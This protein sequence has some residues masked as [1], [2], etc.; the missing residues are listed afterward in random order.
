MN[1][2]FNSNKS[3]GGTQPGS[4]ATSTVEPDQPLSAAQIDQAVLEADE[5]WRQTGK[6][7]RYSQHL[8]KAL[9]ARLPSA[10]HTQPIGQADW[11]A[12]TEADRNKPMLA[13]RWKVEDGPWIY[14]TSIQ[15]ESLLANDIERCQVKDIASPEQGAAPALFV[16]PEQLKWLQTIRREHYTPEG[17][18][19]R[20]LPVR[21][22]PAGLFTQPLYAHP[23]PLAQVN[24]TGPQSARQAMSDNTIRVER[25]VMLDAMLGDQL[26]PAQALEHLMQEE[27]DTLLSLFPGMPDWLRKALIDN[28]EFED[29]FIEW[30]NQDAVSGLAVQF[31][32]PVMKW[33]ASGESSTYSWGHYTTRWFY[34]DSMPGAIAMALGWVEAIRQAERSKGGAL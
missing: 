26:Y 14:P 23:D 22:E 11:R 32:T 9:V 19:G 33:D 16:S 2:P 29:A 15:A 28:V 3:C 31:A 4:G 8:A 5:A 21:A 1:Q 6:I 10:V 13:V 25:I 12:A 20:Y 18:H 30:V 17:E 7:T 34:A 27:T 24:L